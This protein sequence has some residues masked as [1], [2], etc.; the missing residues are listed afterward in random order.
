MSLLLPIVC[1]RSLYAE[2]DMIDRRSFALFRR[3]A[4]CVTALGLALGAFVPASVAQAPQ[5]TKFE[6]FSVDISRDGRFVAGGGGLWKDVPGEV[7]VWELETRKPL[8]RYMDDKG[9]ASVAFSPNGRLLATG[10]WAGH[11]LVL[12]WAAGKQIADF[13]V[14]GVARVAFSPNGELLATATESHKAQ[15]W[16][17]KQFKLVADLQGDLFRFHTVVFSPDGKRV[18]AGGGDWKPGGLNQVTVWDVA[19][20]QQVMK[21]VGHQN[22]IICIAFSPDGKTIASGGI[23]NTIRLWDADSGRTFN[24]LIGHNGW[25]ESLLFLPD[26]KTLVSASHDQTIRF[27]DVDKGLEKESITLPADVRAITL[28]P[29]NKLLLA[30]GAKK[31]L[32]IFD[33]ATHQEVGQLWNGAE[34][35]KGS[36]DDLPITFPQPGVLDE[37]E[38]P[39]AAKAAGTSWLMIFGLIGLV[40]AAALLI[41]LGVW[42]YWRQGRSAE[43]FPA[44]AAGRNN[45]DVLDVEVAAVSFSCGACGKTLKAKAQLAGKKVRCSQCG[46]PVLVPS[47][48][49]DD[50]E[51]LS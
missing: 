22:A 48:Q 36:V 45:P 16:D 39:D 5:N 11:V 27:W 2:V 26:G 49:A 12:D 7:G 8:K 25:V 19:S 3:M 23:D 32:Y 17:M 29:D 38:T 24:T 42:F 4:L 6:V 40:F 37:Q 44:P 13:D 34:P 47:F 51:R 50:A 46:Q 28:S 15:L 9:V 14:G 31:I 18:L 10:S 41:A 20:K 35:V 30:G 43:E 1:D 33:A 21:L